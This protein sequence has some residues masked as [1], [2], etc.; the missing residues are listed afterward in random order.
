MSSGIPAGTNG[1]NIVNNNPPVISPAQMA[2]NLR[3]GLKPDGSKY[4]RSMRK[5]MKATTAEEIRLGELRRGQGKQ[6]VSEDEADLIKLSESESSHSSTPDNQPEYLLSR[7]LKAPSPRSRKKA[8]S[9][10][11]KKI[12]GKKRCSRSLLS[13]SS[14]SSESDVPMNKRRKPIVEEDINIEMNEITGWHPRLKKLANL[15]EYIPLSMYLNTTH[16]EMLRQNNNVPLRTGLGEKSRKKQLLD[17]AKYQDEGALTS[18]EWREAMENQVAFYLDAG[19]VEQAERWDKH[20]TWFTGQPTFITDFR[21]LLKMDIDLRQLYVWQPFVFNAKRY[22]TKYD[23]MKL[24]DSNQQ[25]KDALKGMQEERD[26]LHWYEPSC[27]QPPNQVT[28][29]SDTSSPKTARIRP[30]Y[31]SFRDERPKKAFVCLACS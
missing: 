7:M 29:A 17:V 1:H 31:R 23:Q 14:S 27:R 6:E 2:E 5:T 13:S 19:Q 11:M 8:E 12:F 9:K 15:G 4:P 3:K 20:R 25:V 16:Q 10:I 18:E 21:I 28:S 22:R 24:D 30:S 26:R